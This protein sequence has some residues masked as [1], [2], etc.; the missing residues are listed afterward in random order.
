MVM[1]QWRV[2]MVPD[3]E[4]IQ[5]KEGNWKGSLMFKNGQGKRAVFTFTSNIELL[6]VPDPDLRHRCQDI[7]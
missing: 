6:Y 2:R 4:K 3:M 1:A 7:K 5:S